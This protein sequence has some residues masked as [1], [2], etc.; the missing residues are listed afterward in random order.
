MNILRRGEEMRDAGAPLGG[1]FVGAVGQ[2][3]LHVNPEGE[4][5][6]VIFVDFAPG[7]HT[8]W[9]RHGSGQVLYLVSGQGFV[10]DEN[11]EVAELSPGDTVIAEAGVRHWHGAAPGSNA[12]ATYVACS[13]GDEAWMDAPDV[14]SAVRVDT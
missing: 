14:A 10:Q 7:A 3:P 12:G 13:F 5:V 1:A 2:R 8:H 11:G 4:A 9:H 6:E